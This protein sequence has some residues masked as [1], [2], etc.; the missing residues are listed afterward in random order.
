MSRSRGGSLMPIIGLVVLVLTITLGVIIFGTSMQT[1][2]VESN[3]TAENLTLMPYELATGWW[4]AVA[5]LALILGVG[6]A[7]WHFWG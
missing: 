5:L 6:F 2:Y 3:Y 1:V 7:F 4:S